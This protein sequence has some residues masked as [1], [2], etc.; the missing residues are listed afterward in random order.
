MKILID[1]REQLRL[2]FSLSHPYIDNII[3]KKLEYGDYACKFNDGYSP[4]IVFE[5][6]SISDLYGTM[7]KGYPRFKKEI[8]R[9]QEDEATMFLI[10]EGSMTTVGK[11]YKR[12]M[13]KGVSMIK[14]LF[15]LQAKY[16]IPVVFCNSR[17]EMR[18]YIINMFVALGRQHIAKK[19]K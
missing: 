17:D 18:N 5:R 14:K 13:I 7:G 10:I 4:K 2:E 3:V 15:T 11:G 19:G 6:K 1:S 16:G 9:A 12:S 8:I